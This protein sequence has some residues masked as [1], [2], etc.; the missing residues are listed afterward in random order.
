MQAII[1]AAGMGRRLGELT[2]ENTK[3]MLEVNDIKL[4]DRALCLLVKLPLKRVVMVVGYRADSVR[5]YVG[6]SYN[7]V[8]IVYVENEIYDRTNNIYSLYLARNYLTE[9]DTILLE[10]DLIFEERVLQKL[11]E[12]PYPNLALVD[13]YESWM[14][15]TVVKIDNDNNIQSFVAKKYFD[16]QDIPEYYKTVNIYKFSREFS[17]THY[18]PML[19]AYSQ[20]L[21]NNE[22][23]E[24]VLRVVSIMDNTSIKVLPLEGEKWYEI[25]DIQDLDIASSMFARDD[26]E[27]WRSYT[28]RYGGYWRYPKM[29]DFCYLVNPY[30]PSERMIN[31]MKASFDILVREYPSGMSVNSMLAAKYFGLCKEKIVVGNGAA[32]LIKELVEGYVGVMGVTFPTFEEYPNRLPAERI[33]RYVPSG[34]GFTYGVDDYINFFSDK[35]VDTLLLINPDNPSGN[36]I[37]YSDV[38]KLVEWTKLRGTRLVIDESFVD[39]A[40]VDGEFSL[41]DNE[42]LEQNPHLIVIKSISKSYGVPGLRLGVLASGDEKLISELKKRVAI[43]NINSFGEF[44]MQIFGKYEYDYIR[45]CQ[46]F[47]EERETFFAQLSKIDYLRVFPSQANYFLCEVIGGQKSRDLSIKLLKEYD[48]LIKDCSG[49]EAFDGRQYI[50]LAVRDRIDNSRLI[51]AL[52]NYES[53]R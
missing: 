29:L 24:Q 48:I 34:N 52:K 26:D 10:S 30:Y 1:L 23:Y 28:F 35:R 5:N 18:V 22:Y 40:K 25:D 46:L 3:C 45:A 47:I 38:M 19:I 37:S 7:G 42:V 9:M 31:E 2:I 43:W 36:Y 32:E 14:D 53:S 13:K 51:E 39:F 15:G 4:I 16:W 33:V 50:R 8:E 20:A 11:V 49:K 44:Y 27:Q 12:H 21:G 6:N 17:M 41:L